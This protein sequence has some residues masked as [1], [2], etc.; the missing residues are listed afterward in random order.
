M[1]I[2]LEN[3]NLNLTSGPNHFGQK[4]VKYS[5]MRGVQFNNSIPYDKK[6]TF[7]QSTGLRKDLDMYLRLDGIYFNSGFDFQMVWRAQQL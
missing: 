1:N 5:E 7:I 6:L 2:F 4:L 3:V